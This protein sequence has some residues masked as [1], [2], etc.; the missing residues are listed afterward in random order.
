MTPEQIKWLERASDRLLEAEVCFECL[1]TRTS[2]G[3][4]S[5]GLVAD[6]ELIEAI[7][8]DTGRAAKALERLLAKHKTN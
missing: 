4:I 1:E 5:P 7:V 8:S 3:D 2:E 6:A